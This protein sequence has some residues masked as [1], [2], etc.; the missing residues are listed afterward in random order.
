VSFNWSRYYLRGFPDPV[1]R[2]QFTAWT[3]SAG[4]VRLLTSRSGLTG[5][6]Y[7]THSSSTSERVSPL[8]STTKYAIST[9]GLQFGVAFFVY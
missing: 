6:A 7:Y 4:A 5:E 1:Q 2:S 8:V 3:V 9:F